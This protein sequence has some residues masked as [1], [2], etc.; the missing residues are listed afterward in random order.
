MAR[1]LGTRSGMAVAFESVYGTPPASGYKKVGFVSTTL[2]TAQPLLEDDLAGTGRDPEAPTKDAEMTDGNLVVPI[3]AR[4]IGIWLK[5]LFGAP[6]TSGTGPFT[7]TFNSG[8]F[9]LPSLA[10]EKQLPDV[11]MYEM[12]AGVM[13]NEWQWTMQRSGLL[14][15]SLGLMAQGSTKGAVTGAGTPTDIVLQ[16]FGHFNGSIQRNGSALASVMSTELT[17][18]NGLEAVETI[19]ADGKIDG[20]DPG[21]ASFRGSTVVRFADTT[22]Y[23]QAIAGTA[24][25]LKFSYSLGADVNLDV[26]VPEV[27]LPRPRVEIPGPQGIQV[28]FDWIASKD[29]TTGKLCTVVLENDQAT[30]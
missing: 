3:C 11:P 16:R 14:T 28:T 25:E 26:T 19:R 2:G 20:I 23:D 27:F 18:S 4:T 22:L 7:H 8:S 17:Y 10:I 12:F 9:T 13:V 5:G 24:C 1:A 6:T 29:P 15:M 30:Y 21:K